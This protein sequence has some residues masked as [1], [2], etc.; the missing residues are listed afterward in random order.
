MEHVPAHSRGLELD[1]LPT[2]TILWFFIYIH[3]VCILIHVTFRF[4]T[5]LNLRKLNA[6][7]QF[8]GNRTNTTFLSSETAC[9]SLCSWWQGSLMVSGC[10]GMYLQLAS[11]LSIKIFGQGAMWDDGAAASVL[12]RE[13]CLCATVAKLSM[14]H[15]WV[16]PSEGLTPMWCYRLCSI[17]DLVTDRA[18]GSW[19]YAEWSC[20]SLSSRKQ[21]LTGS[22]PC[23]CTGK[24]KMS[25]LTPVWYFS[26]WWWKCLSS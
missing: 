2:Q 9:V 25:A 7:L 6:N 21:S 10:Y 26:E 22:P 8:K 18:F 3:D 11:V 14:S 4:F 1:D 17:H 23:H 15:L 24:G 12:G 13:D 16:S 20:T 5:L 19:E